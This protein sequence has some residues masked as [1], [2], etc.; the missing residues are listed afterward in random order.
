M[1]FILFVLATIGM[2]EIITQSDLFQYLKDWLI[3]LAEKEKVN[4]NWFINALNC[5]QCVGFWSGITMG[6]IFISNTFWLT[7]ACGCTGS[8]IA[9]LY[10]L[11]YTFIQS[12]TSIILE[13]HESTTV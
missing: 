6:L 5:S 7:F 8:M 13:N 1:M 9:N 10:V 4:I 3:D 11:L 12:K 2:T